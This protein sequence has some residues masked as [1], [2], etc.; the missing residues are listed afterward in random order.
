MTLAR[1]G[2]GGQRRLVAFALLAGAVAGGAALGAVA[3][4]S[5]PTTSLQPE[6]L[7][8]EAAPVASTSS[9][10]YCPGGPEQ[11]G[12][13]TQLLL[14]NAGGR[15][16]RV[17][18]TAVDERGRQGQGTVRLGPHSEIDVVP[19]R[20]VRGAWLASRI[21]VTGGAVSAT[22]LVDG[23]TGR[24]VTQCASEVSTR[25]Y[26][27]S[28]STRGGSTL[29]VAVSNPT[30]DLSVVDLTFVTGSG[31]MTPA[32]FQGLVVDPG[33]LRVLTVGAYVQNQSSVATAVVTRSGAVVADELQRYGPAGGS[34][35]ALTLGAPETSSRWVLPSVEDASGGSSALTVFNPTARRERVVAEVRLPSGPVEPFTQELGPQSVWTLPTS[36][37]LRIATQE[38]YTIVVQA[39]GRGVVVARTGSGAPLGPA[40]WWTNDIVVSWP[41]SSAAHRW[42]LA[43]VPAAAVAGAPAVVS[44]LG[45]PAAST[46]P[47]LVVENPTRHPVRVEVS[48]WSVPT[49]LAPSRHVREVRL[50]SMA[51][52]AIA[53]P[54]ALALVTARGPVAVV[55]DASPPGTAG[56]LVIPAVPLG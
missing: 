22:E 5:A 16:V 4:R 15:A 19:G 12:A 32:P 9:S 28:G 23:H 52:A 43:S 56:V 40:P 51:H 6:A 10:W 30:H 24:T 34:G 38:P 29:E 44:K 53:M 33:A 48:W 2:G 1:M 36:Q 21:D 35:I 50:P 8:A 14:A 18:I 31:F 49:R 37:E 27:A 45:E 41:E 55:G 7:A 25:W 46:R 47:R 3:P 20:L 54:A 17:G 42:V 11:G 39:T 13:T 26:F